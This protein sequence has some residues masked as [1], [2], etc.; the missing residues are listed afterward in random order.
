MASG[1]GD[2]ELWPKPVWDCTNRGDELPTPDFDTHHHYML[3]LWTLR[4]HHNVNI[5]WFRH[6]HNHVNILRL[7][8]THI[9]VNIV[10]SKPSSH[11]VDFVRFRHASSYVHR[12]ISRHAHRVPNPRFYFV[13]TGRKPRFRTKNGHRES[14][15][16][17][18][19]ATLSSFWC[20]LVSVQKTRQSLGP[21]NVV[22]NF[23]EFSEH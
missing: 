9:V 7:W 10:I 18:S 19:G 4:T 15:I 2:S 11:L 5:L 23:A 20:N 8:H 17:M 6:T 21:R 22:W 16:W 3:I 14:G 1:I 12:V 13:H